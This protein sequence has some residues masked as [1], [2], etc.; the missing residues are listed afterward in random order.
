MNINIAVIITCFNRKKKTVAC[1]T[2]LFD[3]CNSYNTAHTETPILLSIY[4]TDDGCTDGTADAVRSSCEGYDLHIIQGNGQCYWAGGMRLAWNEALKRKVTWDFYLL[5]ND[6]T[7]VFNNVFDQL[8]YAHDFALNN[9]QKPGIYSGITCDIKSTNIITYGGEKITGKFQADSLMVEPH[10]TPIEVDKANA[11][12]MLVSKEIVNDI[13]IFHDGYVHGCADYDYSLQAKKHKYPVLVTAQ[14]CGACE[15]D[16]LSGTEEIQ[17]LN[18][19]TFSQRIAYM[20]N[21]VHSDHDYLLCI[22]R[23]IPHK[24]FVSWFLRKIRIVSPNIYKDICLCR[25]LNEY[26]Q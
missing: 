9:Y 21:P 18:A 14:V 26:K 11:N 19:M 24:Y 13:G 1:L 22:K 7:M 6:D 3:A 23:N 25:G 10:E 12:I 5:L 8:F 17:K 20:K 15:F 4:L 2:H 16:H